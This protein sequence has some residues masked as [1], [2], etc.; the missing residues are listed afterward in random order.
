MTY[1]YIDNNIIVSQKI[2]GYYQ[3]VTYDNTQ[4]KILTNSLYHKQDP[5]IS[6]CGNYIAYI[7]QTVEGE[8]YI[9]ESLNIYIP[10][11]LGKE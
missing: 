1:D 5:S 10:E 7:A 4:K 8:R 9:E 6:P 11:S 2:N 3:L